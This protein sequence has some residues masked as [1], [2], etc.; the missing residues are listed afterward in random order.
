[1]LQKSINYVRADQAF[2][3]MGGNIWTLGGW[4]DGGPYGLQ[5]TPD[6]EATELLGSSMLGGEPTRAQALP[7]LRGS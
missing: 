5:C 2:W 7:R 1:M 3:Y 4:G 6:K